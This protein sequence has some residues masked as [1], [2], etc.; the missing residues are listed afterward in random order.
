MLTISE[1]YI[2]KTKIDY[3]VRIAYVS[4]LEDSKKVAYYTDWSTEK[5]YGTLKTATLKGKTTKVAD[6]VHSYRIT[7][8]EQ[9]LYI[10]DFSLTSY[11]GELYLFKG[12]KA[13]K[14]DDD[15]VAILPI[16]QMDN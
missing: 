10:Y 5:Q 2:N 11:K 12:K 9:I 3:D 6:D 15:V 8:D 16:I 1:L 4:Y 7:P 13:E 14:I